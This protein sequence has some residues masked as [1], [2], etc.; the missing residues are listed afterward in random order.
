MHTNAHCSSAV[1]QVP[2]LHCRSWIEVCFGRVGAV[3]KALYVVWVCWFWAQR[4]CFPGL[5]SRE[6]PGFLF[7]FLDLLW[8]VVSLISRAL[9]RSWIKQSQRIKDLRLFAQAL[10]ESGNVVIFTLLYFEEDGME[11]VQSACR[12]CSTLI[13]PNYTINTCIEAMLV[14]KIMFS[15]LLDWNPT[16][17]VI[18][19]LI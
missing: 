12:T 9:G 8:F 5:P 19:E 14:I 4:L 7:I 1:V 6:N 3:V 11:L 13:F 2:W 10:V 15:C 16:K 17:K 18:L